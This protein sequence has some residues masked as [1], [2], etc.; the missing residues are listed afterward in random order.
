M[1]IAF[2]ALNWPKSLT[3]VHK[4]T[5]NLALSL[6]QASA[7]VDFI[8]VVSDE[9]V[10]SS[11][12]GF[13]SF[14]NTIT[15]APRD[16]RS[17]RHSLSLWQPDIFVSD[18]PCVSFFLPKNCIK[19]LRIHDCLPLQI[20]GFFGRNPLRKLRY[21]VRMKWQSLCSD[22]VITDSRYSQSDLL[23]KLRISSSVVPNTVKSVNA[24]L[25]P[26][27]RSGY[28]YVGGIAPR[29]N[30]EVLLVEFNKL[31]LHGLI[32]DQLFIVGSLGFV[33]PSLRSVL[34][35]CLKSGSVVCLGYVS[36]EKLASLY[37]SSKALIYPSSYEGFGMPILE[38]MVYGCPVI[39]TPYTSI[40][41]VGGDAILYFDPYIFGSLMQQ[42]LLLD[43]SS[44]LQS[45]LSTLGRSHSNLFAETIVGELFYQKLLS[46]L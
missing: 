36:E 20:P 6:L 12:E 39:S 45:N 46:L 22:H 10:K 15:V 17:L 2:S 8:F 29:K 1:K 11:L 27:N 35:K 41:E 13:S 7:D 44:S 4:S 14:I 43:H 24:S 37:Q 25:S 18:Y 31:Y 21:M 28:L 16:A 38:A 19:V 23:S 33:Y 30:I 5:I 34:D 32:C 26:H 9:D 42:I 40:P 3:G